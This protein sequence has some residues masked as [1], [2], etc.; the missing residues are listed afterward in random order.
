MYYIVIYSESSYIAVFW[1]NKDRVLIDLKIS[2]GNYL[3]FLGGNH[4]NNVL[5]LNELFSLIKI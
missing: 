3:K 2:S 1:E 5:Y 4:V